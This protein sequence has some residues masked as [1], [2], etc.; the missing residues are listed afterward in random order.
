M[1]T[2]EWLQ[3]AK[4]T[5]VLGALGRFG[6]HGEEV[7]EYAAVQDAKLASIRYYNFPIRQISQQ[8][9]YAAIFRAMHEVLERDNQTLFIFC[10]SGKDRS[11]FLIY[12]F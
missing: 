6:K 7:P 8:S 4:V 2:S 11:C 5:H 9:R 3:W 12:F 1:L 10:K